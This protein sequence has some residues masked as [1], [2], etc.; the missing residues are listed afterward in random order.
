MTDD[1]MMRLR[2]EMIATELGLHKARRD[3]GTNYVPPRYRLGIR[4]GTKTA[5][6]LFRTIQDLAE[7]TRMDRNDFDE[8]TLDAAKAARRQP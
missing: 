2:G 5:V 6:G 3:D 8:G 7:R 4:H 1:D